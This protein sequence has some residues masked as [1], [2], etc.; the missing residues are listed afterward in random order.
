MSLC[1]CMFLIFCWCFMVNMLHYFL[2]LVF[3]W[4]DILDVV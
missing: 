3:C 1:V 2:V 4:L